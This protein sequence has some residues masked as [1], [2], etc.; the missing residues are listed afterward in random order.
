MIRF[1]DEA[2]TVLGRVHAGAPESSVGIRIQVRRGCRGLEYGMAHAVCLEADDEVI[3][4][5]SV[6]VILDP[7]SQFLLMGTIVGF[8]E[9]PE[10]GGFVFANPNTVPGSCGGCGVS[11]QCGPGAGRGGGT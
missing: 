2:V 1:T 6:P 5:G 10:G 3:K 9:R 8:E 7:I 4:A 11:G